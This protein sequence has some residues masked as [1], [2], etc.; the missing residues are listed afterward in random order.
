MRTWVDRIGLVLDRTTGVTAALIL[1][2][3]M[4]LTCV[5]VVGRNL[6][7]HPV[8]GAVELT[9][10]SL[11]LVIFL[12]LPQVTLRNRHIVTTFLDDR[13]GPAARLVQRLVAVVLGVGL[14]GITGWQIWVLAGRAIRYQDT[15]AAL[16]LPMAPI[17]YVMSVLSILN[18][19][20]CLLSLFGPEPEQD[21]SVG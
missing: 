3:V 19:F 6:L 20:A 15:T 4:V 8:M 14:Y 1:L 16:L 18:A 5:D 17:L 7:H 2:F 12:M 10:I 13:L 9:E 21:I 11:F